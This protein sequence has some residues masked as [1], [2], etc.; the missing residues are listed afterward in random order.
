MR[1]DRSLRFGDHSREVRQQ[2]IR[3]LNLIRRRGGNQW[4]W[5]NPQ[6]RMMYFALIRLAAEYA[7]P[8]WFPWTAKTN[9][10][11]LE[12]AQLAVARAITN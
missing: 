9:M 11:Q 1:F 7:A 4:G 6:L 5:R 2:M 8:A 3:R 10:Q 12:T